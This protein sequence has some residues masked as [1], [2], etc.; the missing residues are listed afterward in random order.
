MAEEEIDPSA[1]LV[2]ILEE[3]LTWTKAGMY[4]SVQQ[5]MKN[6]FGDARNE[7]KLA[8]ELLDGKRQ[9]GDII[10]ICKQVVGEAVI[11]SKPSLSKWATKWERLGLVKKDGKKISRLFSLADFGIQVPQLPKALDSPS[12]G[13]EGEQA[14]R[15]ELG[16]VQ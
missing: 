8:Y 9:L 11:I 10:Q 4:S 7:E 13:N 1:R 15:D 16:N 6:Q 14:D 3:M 2:S 12:N 5:L